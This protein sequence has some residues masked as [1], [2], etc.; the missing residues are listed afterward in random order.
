MSVFTGYG[1][2]LP[3][4]FLGEKFFKES[5]IE[6]VSGSGNDQ[7]A[8]YRHAEKREITE[9][10]QNFMSNKLVR[11]AQAVLVDNLILIDDDGIV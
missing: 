4:R 8:E 10:I 6:L 1:A 7:V 3:Y 9:T 11:K 5:V 2:G